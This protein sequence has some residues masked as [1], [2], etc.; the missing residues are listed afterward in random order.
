M[1]GP[2]QDFGIGVAVDAAG[3]VY[4]TGSFKGT[5]D[6]DPGAGV[7]NLTSAG[8]AD[9]FV[10]KLD[11]SGNF[12]W[13]VGMGGPS[14]DLGYG[15]AVDAGGNVYITG[16]FTGTVDF[17]P[18]AGMTNLTSVGS[19][20]VF[21]LKLA[22]A[23][24]NQD[25]DCS[26]AAIA[27]QSADANCQATISGADVTGV[28]DPD[29]DPLTITVSPTTLV[30]GANTVT[31]TADDGNGGMCSVDITVNVVDDPPPTLTAIS[32]PITLWPPNHKYTTF[33]VD[34]CVES[35]SDNC[36]SLSESN[37]TITRVTS[38]EEEDASGG[39][40]GNTDDDIM[41]AGDCGSVDLRKE[42]QGG[43]NGRV[44]TIYLSVKDEAGNEAT[45]ECQV[46]VPR[47][48]VSTAID[49]GAVYEVVSSCSGLGKSAGNGDLLTKENTAP[50]GYSFQQNYPNPFNP[51]TNI[52]F[53]LPE[54]GMVSLKVYNTIGELVAELVNGQM[55]AGSYSIPFNAS[56]LPSG[57]YLYRIIVNNF[58]SAKKM[59][60]T[61]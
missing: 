53:S 14:S 34:D 57:I 30:L 6:F 43:G 1:G 33:T 15:V 44:Y 22:A 46:H 26:I 16:Y 42:R 52:K 28:T 23:V 8:E 21:V 41:I 20:D 51:S 10:Q 49:D 36:S 56:D 9:V 5:V 40:D 32:D 45:A 55:E 50:K 39:G 13:V 37:V 17:D 25:P 47:N 35:V 48:I 38:D 12:V 7:T 18:G 54:S 24:T 19:I 59:I 3:N 29:G 4:T 2:S 11:L 60:L 58:V 61:K 27:D 31:V